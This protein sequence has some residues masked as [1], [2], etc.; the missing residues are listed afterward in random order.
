MRHAGTFQGFPKGLHPVV[1]FAPGLLEGSQLRVELGKLAAGPFQL[2]FHLGALGELFLKGGL[3]PRQGRLGFGELGL[4]ARQLPREGRQLLRQP[5]LRLARGLELGGQVLRLEAG[6][7]SRLPEALGFS[8]GILH[9]APKPIALRQATAALAVKAG[10]LAFRRLPRRLGRGQPLPLLALLIFELSA[11]FLQTL[12]PGFRGLEARCQGATLGQLHPLQAGAF[13]KAV[14]NARALGLKLSKLGAMPAYAIFPCFL[15]SAVL[16]QFL[17]K[18]FQ[19]LPPT[20]YPRFSVVTPGDAKPAG[21]DH[22]PVAG[23]D[24]LLGL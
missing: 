7:V 3:H 22:D 19:G 24:P 10:L 17:R 12:G 8:P 18:G 16:R 6:L 11:L 20:Q 4:E 13:I 9:L 15:G 21:A 23:D 5:G 1:G 2:L 14:L